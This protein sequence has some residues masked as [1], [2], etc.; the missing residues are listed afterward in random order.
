[1]QEARLEDR[2]SIL[3]PRLQDTWPVSDKTANYTAGVHVRQLVSRGAGRRRSG[4]H[5]QPLMRGPGGSGLKGP[6]WIWTSSEPRPSTRC[7]SGH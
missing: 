1:M 6:P 5:V 4:V 3:N 7:D 2:R